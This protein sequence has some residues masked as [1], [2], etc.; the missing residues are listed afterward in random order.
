MQ[1]PPKENRAYSVPM[2]PKHSGHGPDPEDN[3]SAHHSGDHCDDEEIA[4]DEFFQRYHFPQ[5]AK[6]EDLSES[7]AD[8]S[9]DTEGP[10]SPT[11]VQNRLP[12]HAEEAASSR[13]PETS[14]A[15]SFPPVRE[16]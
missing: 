4:G 11:H 5:S 16:A 2:I 12:A 1:S 7:S 14:V 9:S 6:E 15:V 8:S 3:T 10:I 13:S